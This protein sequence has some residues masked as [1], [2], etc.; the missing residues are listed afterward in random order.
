MQLLPHA[1]VSIMGRRNGY[2]AFVPTVAPADFIKPANA[3]FEWTKP[4]EPEATTAVDVDK[5]K[6]R[7]SITSDYN[8]SSGD[9][10]IG[11]DTTGGAITVTLPA[12]TS[13]GEGKIYIIKDEGGASATNSI[14]VQ[15][16]DNARI[17][18]LASVTLSSNYCAIS[19]YFNAS[20]WHI[21]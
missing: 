6:R 16:A 12:R 11:V 8:V 19:I 14:K 2:K 1:V 17:D 10:F 13:V 15:C 4:P 9:H 18:N 5:A 20:D 21:Y 3:K 7:L